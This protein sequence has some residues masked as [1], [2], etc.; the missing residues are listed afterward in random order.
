MEG[1]LKDISKAV[2]SSKKPAHKL[3]RPGTEECP[4]ERFGSVS[5]FGKR[6]SKRNTNAT[7]LKP[8]TAELYARME[9]ASTSKH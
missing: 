8:G 6:I 4:G 5:A 2:V 1:A 7:R 3:G 9:I